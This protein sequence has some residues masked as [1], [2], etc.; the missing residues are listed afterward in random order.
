MNLR[1]GN[2]LKY[3]VS[4]CGNGACSTIWPGATT[5]RHLTEFFQ[6]QGLADGGRCFDVA[7]DPERNEARIYMDTT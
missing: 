4:N 3:R 7:V 2:V 6:Y 1:C 5:R